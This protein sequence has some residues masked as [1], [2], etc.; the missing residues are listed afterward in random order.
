M[1]CVTMDPPVLSDNQPPTGLTKAPTK[2]P[3]QAYVSAEGALGFFRVCC[4]TP[5]ASG[6]WLMP[7]ITVM[8][9][10]NAIENP[11]KLPKVTM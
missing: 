4:S 5:L 3:I 2:G 6:T 8:D 11:M 10:G 7:K 9:S 1:I